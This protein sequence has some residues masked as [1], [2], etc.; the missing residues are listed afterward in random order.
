MP[1]RTVRDILL[2]AHAGPYIAGERLGISRPPAVLISALLLCVVALATGC[3]QPEPVPWHDDFSDPKS[4]WQAESDAAAKVRYADG[5]LL[6]RVLWPNTLS[7][8]SASRDFAD[9]HLTVE[10]SQV[11]GPD[12]N[13]YG[14]LTRIQDGQQF[15]M[16]AI[17][18]DGYFRIVKHEDGEERLL[19][20][21]WTAS[22][23]IK[24]GAATNLLAIDCRG[25]TMTLAVNGVVLA[26][27]RDDGYSHG[28]IALYAGSF[29]DPGEGVEI[30][31]DNLAVTPSLSE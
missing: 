29:R 5:V 7:W 15:Y 6:I 24:P 8:A 20:A 27:V 19:S 22:P 31:F 13:E 28:D 10:A 30:H 16:F 3:A 9:F 4:G 11:A 2:L 12:D 25:S 18:G 21:D 14:V 23:A 1:S 26:E 17:S